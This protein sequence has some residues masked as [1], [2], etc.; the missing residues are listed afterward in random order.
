MA[1]V[2]Q[3]KAMVG[4][5]TKAYKAGT[6]QIK[7]SNSEVKNS[8]KQIGGALASAFSIAAITRAT[9][10]LITFA[11]E[12]R[13]TADNLD[14]S[15]ESLQSLNAA[16]LKYGLSVNDVTKL[17]GKLR[18][19]QGQVAQG[20]T[21]YIDA[22]KALNIEQAK[23]I[24]ADSD[25]AL[26]MIARAY[27][28]AGRSAESYAAVVDILGRQGKKATAFLEELAT[29]SMDGLIAEATAAGD[30][31]NDEIIT[32]L[33]LAGT[34]MEQ[35]QNKSRVAFAY[36]VNATQDV[37]ESM[38]LFLRALKEGRNPQELFAEARALDNQEQQIKKLKDLREDALRDKRAEAAI[39][40]QLAEIENKRQEKLAKI[41][42]KSLGVNLSSMEQLG[43]AFGGRQQS[44]LF[45]NMM[46]RA[47]DEQLAE[48]TAKATESIDLKMEDLKSQLEALRNNVK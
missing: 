3:L 47:K 43:A 20:D 48:A 7:S 35:L 23:F 8:F 17:M 29:T 36:M 31:I 33:E 27:V 12:I 46:V 37:G 10:A 24:R 5:D 26:E 4:M 18:Q 40:K 44:G 42:V 11:S 34:R 22:L 45:Q 41:K 25:E 16:A 13:H 19:S 38:G 21:T 9:K 39:E 6:R 15:T 28:K 32:N 2:A 14:V 1:G 30:V